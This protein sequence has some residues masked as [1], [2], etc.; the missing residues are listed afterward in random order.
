MK[1]WNIQYQIFIYKAK[2]EF[3][4]LKVTATGR[5]QKDCQLSQA[6][7]FAL[8]N[9]RSQLERKNYNVKIIFYSPS[10]D[11]HGMKF[12]HTTCRDVNAV[13]TFEEKNLFL[14]SE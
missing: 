14:T 7:E 8:T 11:Y 9:V 3:I 2:E 4:A 1:Y 12:R 6:F 5:F 13:E 10:G